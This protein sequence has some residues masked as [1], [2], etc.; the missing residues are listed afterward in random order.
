MMKLID[1]AW[2]HFSGSR[3][4]DAKEKKRRKKGAIELQEQYHKMWSSTSGAIIFNSTKSAK[5]EKSY[6][7]V[8]PLTTP[9][10]SIYVVK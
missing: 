5:F 6:V 8:L 7:D 2:A 4:M 3:T 10:K 1:F 9:S